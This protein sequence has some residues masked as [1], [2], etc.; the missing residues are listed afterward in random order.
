MILYTI[1]HGYWPAP[2]RM[3]GMIDAL[4]A[5]GVKLLVDTRHSPCSSNVEP[6]SNYGPRD[7]NL[8]AGDAG[9]ACQLDAAG[10]DYRWLGELGNPQK[11]DPAMTVLREHLSSRDLRWPVNRGLIVLRELLDGGSCALLCA[12]AD[13]R[14]CHRTVIAETMRERHSELAIEVAHLPA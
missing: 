13:W 1:G 7:W 4:H 5:A 6:G 12:C 11:N 10:I 2:R 3:K 9:I 8:Q 14:E